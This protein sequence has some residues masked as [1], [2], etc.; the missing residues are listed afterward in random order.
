M[1]SL[2]RSSADHRHDHTSSYYQYPKK[3]SV[4]T[5]DGYSFLTLEFQPTKAGFT[6]QGSQG[7]CERIRN[8]QVNLIFFGKSQGKVREENFYPFKFLT[9]KKTICME[10]CVPLNFI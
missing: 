8:S 5:P 2:Y 10:K 4:L 7:I 9:L 3:L 6:L 1:Y